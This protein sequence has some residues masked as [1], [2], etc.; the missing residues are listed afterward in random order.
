MY[1]KTIS[2]RK[3]IVFQHERNYRVYRHIESICKYSNYFWNV[4]FSS[5]KIL[6]YTVILKLR[7]ERR[8]YP[9]LFSVFEKKKNW[10]RKRKKVALVHS[11]RREWSKKREFKRSI[12]KLLTPPFFSSVSILFPF[13]VIPSSSISFF[14]FFLCIFFYFSEHSSYFCALG[15]FWGFRRFFIL[16]IIVYYAFSYSFIYWCL[17]LLT[18][19]TV[20]ILI[21]KLCNK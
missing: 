5:D 6:T 17:R 7:E 9:R 13:F 18:F 15:Y 3:D 4:H 14:T 21:R 1:V 12:Q 8:K 10:E 16:S 20:F 11:L 19:I 2:W